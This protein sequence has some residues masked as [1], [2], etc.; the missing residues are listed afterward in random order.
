MLFQIWKK[1]R[2]HNCVKAE[3]WQWIEYWIHKRFHH[4]ILTDVEIR[5][6]PLINKK[7]SFQPFCHKAIKRNPQ[8]SQ[9][10]S[11]FFVLKNFSFLLAGYWL[12]L[13]QNLSS[14]E[15]LICHI[16]K[17]KKPDKNFSFSSLQEK[18]NFIDSTVRN[19]G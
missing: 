6:D 11:S 13:E 1:S 8:Y 5:T 15:Q 7:T 14:F 3:K 10:L 17:K 12:E 18:K 9:F 4:S 16:N 2:R 19:L